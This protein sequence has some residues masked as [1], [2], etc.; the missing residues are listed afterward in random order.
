MAES[1]NITQHAC[2]FDQIVF[3]TE[4]RLNHPSKSKQKIHAA[5]KEVDFKNT[6]PKRLFTERQ[7]WW[8]Q[9]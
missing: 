1:R 9:D 2:T 4:T 7:I 8:G 6:N 5:A 3:H